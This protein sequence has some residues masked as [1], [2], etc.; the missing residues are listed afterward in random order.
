[1]EEIENDTLENLVLSLKDDGAYN[2]ILFKYL[3]TVQ[4]NKP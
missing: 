1:V 2:S 3:T 4:K